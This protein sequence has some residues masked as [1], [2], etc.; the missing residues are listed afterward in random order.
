MNVVA[1]TAAHIQAIAP[2]CPASMLSGLGYREEMATNAD[3]LGKQGLA[4]AGVEDGEVVVAAGVIPYGWPTGHAWCLLSAQA[5]RRPR[6]MV[7]ITRA[8]SEF[9]DRQFAIDRF[10]RIQMTV[11][12]DYA[13][14]HSWARHL[15]FVRETPAGMLRYLPDGGSADLYA[16]LG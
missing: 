10:S 5:L 11:R 1:C 3:A 14:G 9:L 8:V 4:F 13:A 15:G 7:A 16:R 12:S 6:L 2:E